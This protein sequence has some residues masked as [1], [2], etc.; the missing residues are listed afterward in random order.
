ME[1]E[2]H[3]VPVAAL[4]LAQYALEETVESV[5]LR[6]RARNQLV[7]AR[8]A[9]HREVPRVAGL[10]IDRA[11]AGP[12]E[13]DLES[14]PERDQPGR[15]HRRQPAGKRVF[16]AE[17]GGVV[18]GESSRHFRAHRVTVVDRGRHYRPAL[19]VEHDE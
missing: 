17:P 6:E 11:V 14:G 7:I 1:V 15:G 2:H 16:L 18:E 8:L 9:P 5:V 10:A 12:I 4:A 3:E 13:I 19:L